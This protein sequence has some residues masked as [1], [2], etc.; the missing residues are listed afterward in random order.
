VKEA[1]TK[2]EFFMNKD[3]M[4]YLMKGYVI[5]N[6]DQIKDLIFAESDSPF[7]Y[8]ARDYKGKTPVFNAQSEYPSIS[9]MVMGKVVGYCEE[10]GKRFLKVALADSLSY[11][12]MSDPCIKVNGYCTVGYEDGQDFIIIDKVTRLT[13]ADRNSGGSD[14]YIPSVKGE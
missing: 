8:A 6:F 14:L 3:N 10:D 7:V 1:V 4:Q 11:S 9:D 13:I 5:K 12:M 2:I